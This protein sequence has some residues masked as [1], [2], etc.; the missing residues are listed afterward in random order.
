MENWS[1]AIKW[2]LISFFLVMAV[3]ANTYAKKPNIIFVF[4]DDLG[5]G[6]L[7]CYGK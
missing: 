6:D 3:S 1:K 4:A 7:G 5:F 2:H